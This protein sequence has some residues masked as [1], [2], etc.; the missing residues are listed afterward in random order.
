MSC[1]SYRLIPLLK[2]ALPFERASCTP[3]APS[4]SSSFPPLLFVAQ[5]SPYVCCL[6]YPI[7]LI[8]LLPSSLESLEQL[9]PP[10]PCRPIAACKSL[11]H[12]HIIEKGDNEVEADGGTDGGSPLR[13]ERHSDESAVMG[14]TPRWK[15]S[16]SC[17]AKWESHN[18]VRRPL[19][20]PRFSERRRHLFPHLHP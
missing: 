3:L 17:S 11:M 19:W 7:L 9:T 8:L 6:S 20:R 14:G 5:L 15:R 12:N 1:L 10:P 13:A 4:S 16:H 18:L 2:L